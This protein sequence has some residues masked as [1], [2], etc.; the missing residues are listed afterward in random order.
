MGVRRRRKGGKVT[1]YG[2]PLNP[3]MYF[4]VSEREPL[5][6]RYLRGCRA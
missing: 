1:K 6:N 2:A 5:R 4:R 3:D